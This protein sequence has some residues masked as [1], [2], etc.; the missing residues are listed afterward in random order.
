MD[1]ADRPRLRVGVVGCGRVGA[2]LGAALRDAGHEVVATSAVSEA[3]L[4][5]AEALLPGVPIVAPDEVVRRADLVLMTIPDDQIASVVAGFASLGLFDEPKI[6]A[7]AAGA[8]GLEPLA[9]VVERGGLAFVV[10]PA[11]T[12]SGEAKDVDRLVGT[13]FAVTGSWESLAVGQSLVLDIEGEPFVL[14]ENQRATYHAALT[15]SANHTVTLV[16]QA[17]QLLRECGVDNPERVLRPLMEATV[18]NALQRGDRALTG[19]VS[20]GDVG[21]V[22]GHLD[23]LEDHAPDIAETYRALARA[24]AERAIVM[25]RVPAEQIGALREVLDES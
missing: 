24:T 22:A 7:H 18:D 9:P 21:T 15:H 25:R 8:L 1:S 12:F 20:R 14:P 13:V 19:P 3:S 6:V 5:R 4:E 10:H 2:V 17:M 11:M 23:T 16:A